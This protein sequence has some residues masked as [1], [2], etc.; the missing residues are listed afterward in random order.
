MNTFFSYVLGENE[1][2]SLIFSL[3]PKGKKF[4]K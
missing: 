1:N 3:K 2:A 4:K